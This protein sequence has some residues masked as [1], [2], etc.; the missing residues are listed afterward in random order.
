MYEAPPSDPAYTDVGPD[1]DDHSYGSLELAAAWALVPSRDTMD[2]EADLDQP[3]SKRARHSGDEGSRESSISDSILPPSLPS[4]GAEEKGKYLTF[5]EPL[6]SLPKHQ[7]AGDGYDQY[8]SPPESLQDIGVTELLDQDC[9]PTFIL[10]LQSESIKGQLNVVFCNRSFRFF[11]DLRN[12]VLHHHTASPSAPPDDK[13]TIAFRQ[14]AMST[15]DGIDRYLP[16]HTFRDLYW[17]C[18]TMRG[19][20]R[21][22]SA[23]HVPSRGPTQVAPRSARPRTNSAPKSVPSSTVPMD[24][25][26]AS[27]H[28]MPAKKEFWKQ[29]AA[30]G[31]KFKVLTELNPVGMYCL[32]PAGNI[33]YANDICMSM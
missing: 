28:A 23:S 5:Y 17:T 21:I 8:S 33:V 13:A 25:D 32:T 24:S 4:E 6:P 30:G 29:I 27:K 9:R 7:P 31:P 20:W 16:G 11:D 3:P 26:N 19:R 15:M 22:V 14:W 2:D 10:D 12:V 1:L 18:S